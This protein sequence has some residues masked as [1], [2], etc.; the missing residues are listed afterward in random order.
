[1]YVKVYHITSIDNLNAILS[2][3]IYSRSHMEKNGTFRDIA[4]HGALSNHRFAMI[5]KHPVDRFARCFFNPLPP[6]YY[7]RKDSERLCILELHIPIVVV[8]KFLGGQQ[9]EFHNIKIEGARWPYPRIYKESISAHKGNLGQIE[10]HNL[11]NIRWDSSKAA[12]DANPQEAKARRG[13]E[14]AVFEHIP[15]KY[16]K[17]I[18]KTET[19]IESLTRYRDLG[20]PQIMKGVDD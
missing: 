1:M 13:A 8:S 5:D 19:E 6:M 3:G 7:M 9:R 16:I 12:F 4:E 17:K 10:V 2:S 20:K 14:M 18:Y 11:N 15:S